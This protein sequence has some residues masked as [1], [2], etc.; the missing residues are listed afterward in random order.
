MP[1]SAEEILQKVN[2]HRNATDDLRSRMEADY[3][4]WRLEEYDAGEDYE[5]YTSNEPRAYAD[6]IIAWLVDAALTIRMPQGNAQA[7]RKDAMSA[8]ER[9]LIGILEAAD[10]RLLELILPGIREQ[11]AW[12]IT[13]RGWWASLSILR[14]LENGQTIVDIT[15]WD[16]MHTYWEVGKNG[17]LA[18]ACY[19]QRKTKSRILADHDFEVDVDNSSNEESFD[20]YSYY[21]Q[22]EH[23]LIIGSDNQG[24]TGEIVRNAEPHG[25]LRVPVSIG[26]VGATPPI[27]GYN[28]SGEDYG[29]DIGESVFGSNR[30]LYPVRNKIMSIMLELVARSK[31]QPYIVRS[32]DGSKTLEEDPSKQGS[33]VAIAEG[34]DVR[35]MEQLRMAIDT[36]PFLGN[37]SAELQRG[38][39][40]YSSFGELGF[41]LSGFAIT[42]LNDNI[43]TQLQ[44][45]S[46]AM[47]RAYRQICMLVAD[48]YETGGFESFQVNGFT[49][50]RDYFSETIEPD[51]IQGTGTPEFTLTAVLPADDAGKLQ[52]AQIAREGPVPLLPDQ[53]IWDTILQIQNPDELSNK[54]KEQL[55]EQT[56]PK[57]ALFTLIKAL[58]ERG[59]QELAMIY[60]EELQNIMLQE[61]VAKQQMMMGG[62][63][64]GGGPQQPG[65]SGPSGPSGQVPS[66]VP[67]NLPPEILPPVMQGAPMPVPTPQAGPNVPPGSPRP[68][69]LSEDERLI[70]GP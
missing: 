12:Q 51:L 36:L 50:N 57:A 67:P 66:P 24:G 43:G 65:P 13:L 8:K 53:Y 9:F 63:P 70:G 5:S 4:L 35:P 37:I 58:M 62:M 21:D 44:P 28:G 32:R 15:P 48:Q 16:P 14:K 60:M 29:S 2:S 27:Q 56:S 19:H 46:R 45:R 10:E 61:F 55:G 23:T 54:I 6:K 31:K 1:P 49:S 11:L 39:I 42:Q 40:P 38:S 47:Q 33:E 18:W 34:D 64:Q 30:I 69:R 41:Q 3:L 20:V 26:M 68:G 17:Q 59:S 22:K 7:A 52:M 25:G